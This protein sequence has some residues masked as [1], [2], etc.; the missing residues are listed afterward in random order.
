MKSLIFQCYALAFC[1]S[2]AVAAISI[3]IT[4]RQ[5]MF[6]S[7]DAGYHIVKYRTPILVKVP[8]GDL[9]AFSAPRKY[10][11]ADASPKYIAQRRSTDGGLHWNLTEFI[12]DDHHVKDGLS[13][14]L[15]IID[16]DTNTTFILFGYCLHTVGN[17]TSPY[18]PK[19]VYY[20]KST[21]WGYT[22]SAPINVGNTNPAL[23][24]LAWAP[25]PGFGIQKKYAP[26][27]GRLIGCGHM[28][29]AMKCL[30]S[31]DH[32]KTWHLNNPLYVI[33]Y[34][35]SRT[36][37]DFKPDETQI[38]ELNNGNIFATIRNQERFHCH[39]RL[40][41]LS[42][43]GGI[44]F[45]IQNVTAEGSLLDPSV[46]ASLALVNDTL[47]LSHPYNSEKRVDMTLQWS[48][49]YGKTW[50]HR[51]QVFNGSS[52]YSSLTQIDENN[53][54]LLFERSDYEYIEFYKIRLN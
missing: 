8:N 11:G 45:P 23:M 33:P 51:Y 46:F 44:T 50:P 28:S 7:R 16:S 54:G 4:H 34:K 52:E 13:L 30:Y 40:Q 53:L 2:H 22:W 21:D 38:I 43:D 6:K 3:N 35:Q 37:G 17:C 25:G 29:L 9:L 24:G 47:F 18:R 32:G 39:C 1:L 20:K 41:G 14:G 49:D 36:A 5:E 27:K 26:N 10:T 42:V 48:L 31:D 19:G 12:E 15:V